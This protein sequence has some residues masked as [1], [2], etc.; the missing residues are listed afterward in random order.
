MA[1][2]DDFLKRAREHFSV[3]M[4]RMADARKKKLMQQRFDVV[5]LGLEALSKKQIPAAASHFRVFLHLLEEY[6]EVRDG[7]LTPSLFDAKNEMGE[8]LLMLAV[9]WELIK[10]Y[11]HSKSADGTAAFRNYLAKFVSFSKG[12]PVQSLSAEAVRR[13]LLGGRPLHAQEFR[14]AYDQLG[15]KGC[16]VVTSLLDV[17][18]P[19]TLP[20]LRDFR[21]DRLTR[22]RMGR[23]LIK[24]YYACGP[25][26]ASTMDL[27]PMP[28]RRA[29]GAL[30]DQIARFVSP[31]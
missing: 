29:A 9:Y 22:T 26:L 21:D 5:S 6:K 14:N 17:T 7:E 23:V 16:F 18:D 10:M 30:V 11:D 20:A 4:K 19:A 8:I 13:Y 31:E 15:K 1:T 2:R 28:V 27:M 25:Y 12:L 3:Q 24:S